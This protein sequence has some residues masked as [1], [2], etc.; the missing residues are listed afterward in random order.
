MSSSATG[1]TS[2]AK[3]IVVSVSTLPSLRIA[4][5]FSLLRRTKRAIATLPEAAI[6]FASSEY[7]FS[8]P[9]AGPR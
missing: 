8:A 5:R 6:A 4:A 1:T 9:S 7:A 3:R 2:S